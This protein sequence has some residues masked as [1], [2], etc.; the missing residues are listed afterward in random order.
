MGSLGFGREAS[1]SIMEKQ[2]GHLQVLREGS[3]IW[4]S[5]SGWKRN[6]GGW[7][8]SLIALGATSKDLAR[9]IAS[10][11]P[12]RSGVTFRDLTC[13]ATPRITLAPEGVRCCPFEVITQITM[14]RPLLYTFPMADVLAYMYSLQAQTMD[15][16]NE[17]LMFGVGILKV[18]ELKKG[19]EKN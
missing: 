14:G 10:P 6:G 19:R 3:W 2:R 4:Q 11:T 9:A 13:L 7:G 18:E 1:T 5:G 8:R 15:K 17:A 12:P 16:M